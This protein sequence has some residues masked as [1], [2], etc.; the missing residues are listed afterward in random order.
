[1]FQDFSAA[2]TGKISEA[3]FARWMNS[4]MVWR[5]EYSMQ[6][7]LEHPNVVAECSLSQVI[8]HHAPLKY[9]LTTPELQSLLQ[10]AKV[11]KKALPIDLETAIQKQISTLS[12]MPQLEEY[13]HLARKHADIAVMEKLGHLIREGELML[14]V[15][16]L[17]PSEYEKL[18]GFPEG[19]TDLDIQA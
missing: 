2:K 13:I 11:R 5:G 12:K 1:M 19:W 3:S 10:R 4:G 15:R 8:D 18:Q 17:L 16:R 6:N 7:T 14:S 9:F